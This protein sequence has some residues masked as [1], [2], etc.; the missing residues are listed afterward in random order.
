ME[1]KGPFVLAGIL[2]LLGL[3]VAQDDAIR[4]N[5][6][7]TAANAPIDAGSKV[8]LHLPPSPVKDR[9]SSTASDGATD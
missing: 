6:Q 5:R 9:P 4:S 3:D 2:L 1:R 8:Q 7:V